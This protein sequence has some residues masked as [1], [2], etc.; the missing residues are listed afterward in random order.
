MY[1]YTNN[2]GTGIRR[3]ALMDDSHFPEQK[4]ALF[5]LV[6]CSAFINYIRAAEVKLGTTS[7]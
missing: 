3:H 4:E 2:K 5:M 7:R 1:N 6:Y